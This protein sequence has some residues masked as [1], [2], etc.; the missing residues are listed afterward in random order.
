[1]Q[2]NAKAEI[3]QILLKDSLSKGIL[4]MKMFPKTAASVIVPFSYLRLGGRNQCAGEKNEVVA[5]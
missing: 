3:Y 5:A 2:C 4:Y 1:M